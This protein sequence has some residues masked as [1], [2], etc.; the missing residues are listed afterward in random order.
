M[1][2]TRK[3][4]VL[5]TEAGAQKAGAGKTKCRDARVFLIELDR[6]YRRRQLSE[7]NLSKPDAVKT[8]AAGLS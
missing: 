2:N 4:H 6:D 8:H 5:T 3:S 7:L 1:I